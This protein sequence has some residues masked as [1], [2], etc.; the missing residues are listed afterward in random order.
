MHGTLPAA[1]S[2]ARSPEEQ[3]ATSLVEQVV[4]DGYGVDARA[5]RLTGERDQ[6]FRMRTADDSGFV[7]K[8][9]HAE[10]LPVVIDLPIAALLHLERADPALPCPRVVRSRDRTRVTFRDANGAE[11]TAFLYTFLPGKP[12]LSATRCRSQ[13]TACGRLL[14]R[15]G[16]ALRAFQHPATRRS[17]IWDL[18]QV[19]ALDAVLHRLPDMRYRQFCAAFV[20]QFSTE[21]LPRLRALRS[22]PVHNDFNSR[23][24]LVDP[25]DET[26]ITGIIDFGDL[27]HTALLADIAVG[28]IGQLATAQSADEAMLEFVE[29]YRS[30]EPLRPEELELLKWLI[31]GRI[32]QNVTMTSWYRAHGPAG[33]HFD[34]F[35][36]DYFEWRVALAERLTQTPSPFL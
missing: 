27:V 23:N 26:R 9:A 32:V 17:L 13:R 10:E 21:I 12:L 19:P 36:A 25:D 24:L 28:V 18:M 31:A 1:I 5:E 15:L 3:I 22:Q 33:G 30:V 14:A 4:R 7:L 20:R 8:I 6:N 2:A 35:D 29:G 34:T 11:R 16:H